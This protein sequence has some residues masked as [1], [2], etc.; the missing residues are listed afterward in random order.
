[1]ML[2]GKPKKDFMERLGLSHLW[3]RSSF[4]KR[5]LLICLSLVLALVSWSAVGAEDGFYVI[6]GGKS[7]SVPKTGQTTPYDQNIPPKDDGALKKGVA[8][9]TPRFTDNNN[10]TITD[11]LTKLIWMKDANYVGLQTWQ[12][13]LN[14]AAS[15]RGDLSRPMGDGGPRDGSKPGDWRLPNLRELQSLIDYAFSYPALPNT[16]GTGQ[17]TEGNPFQ[18]V[19]YYY[20]W[21]S[22]TLAFNTAY[23]WYVSFSGGYLNISDK[24]D[25]NYVQCVRGGP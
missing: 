12:G 1:M 20:Y 23:A 9:P 4:M 13:A 11:N 21:S 2:T 16:L 17:W 22:S 7:A 25:S 10:G 5:G 24:S 14:V 6:G 18:G 3:K 8:W 19:Q 15:M